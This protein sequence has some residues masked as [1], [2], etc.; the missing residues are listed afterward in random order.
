[1][2]FKGLSDCLMRDVSCLLPPPLQDEDTLHVQI[3]AA[4]FKLCCENT[5]PCTLCM[6]IDIEVNIDLE[7]DTLDEDHSG[8]QKEDYNEDVRTT[9]G[10]TRINKARREFSLVIPIE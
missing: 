6:G 3:L 9:K 8:Q 10:M 2:S 4:Y 7:K 1:M 5:A